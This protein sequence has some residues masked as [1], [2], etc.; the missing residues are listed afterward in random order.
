MG[1]GFGATGLRGEAC[2][3]PAADGIIPFT[4]KPETHDR[5][6]DCMYS[7]DAALLALCKIKFG[8]KLPDGSIFLD[9]GMPWTVSGKR[10]RGLENDAIGQLMQGLM[11]A[12]SGAIQGA[13]DTAGETVY[14]DPA[15]GQTHTA[16]PVTGGDPLS[17]AREAMYLLPQGGMVRITPASRQPANTG[18]DFSV[19]DESSKK[20]LLGGAIAF[21]VWY[22]LVKDQPRSVSGFGGY[23][24]RRRKSRR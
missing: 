10:T 19:S 11:R 14:T 18:L 16:V 2:P 21:G 8:E 3:V 12:A 22:F 17:S 9:P 7:S 1:F 24:R 4:F 6:C 13:L 15:T 23:R 20:L 5:W